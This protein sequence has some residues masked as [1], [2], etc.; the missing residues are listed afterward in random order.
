M[1]EAI[2]FQEEMQQF[3]MKLPFAFAE[4]SQQNR[5]D[6]VK[7]L[8]GVVASIDCVKN[9]L[10]DVFGQVGRGVSILKLL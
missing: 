8:I 2:H 5:F 1:L 3:K 7:R 9:V 10:K 6:I 4:M